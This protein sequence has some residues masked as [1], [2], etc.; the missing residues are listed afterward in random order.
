MRPHTIPSSLYFPVTLKTTPGETEIPEWLALS[1]NSNDFNPMKAHF[2]R[3]GCR[4]IP[5]FEHALQFI[6]A[7]V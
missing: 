2:S 6:R 7:K 1:R 5:K 3:L 4:H